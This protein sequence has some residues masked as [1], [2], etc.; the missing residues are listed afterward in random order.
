MPMNSTTGCRLGENGRSFSTAT[1]T[2]DGIKKNKRK[3]LV[4]FS[5][6]NASE[7]TANEW[8]VLIR[9]TGEKAQ[10]SVYSVLLPIS[11]PKN[12]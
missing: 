7:T 8:G 11:R 1:L 4:S 3:K 12:A 10:H 9:T 6:G 5:N 2:A